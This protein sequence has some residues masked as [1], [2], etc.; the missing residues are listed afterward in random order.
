[1]RR[2]IVRALGIVMLLNLC[3]SLAA[4][5]MSQESYALSQ[6]KKVKKDIR[7]I[8]NRFLSDFSAI[9]LGRYEQNIRGYEEYLFVLTSKSVNIIKRNHISDPIKKIWK[10]SYNNENCF[11]NTQKL[12]I[13][14]LRYQNIRDYFDFK[15]VPLYTYSPE[16]NGA[17]FQRYEKL[18]SCFIKNVLV[19]TDWLEYVYLLKY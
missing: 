7:T 15:E 3:F 4:P 16:C 13:E 18:E 17:Y 1:M 6:C 2:V 10:L 8:E 11:T 14:E 9:R 19:P 5:N 12:R